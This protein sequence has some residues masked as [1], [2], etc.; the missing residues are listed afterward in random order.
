MPAS[1]LRA[2][3]AGTCQQAFLGA[4]C[5]HVPASILESLERSPIDR[6]LSSILE[7]LRST[8]RGGG[9]SAGALWRI[10]DT[11]PSDTSA[12]YATC[13]HCVMGHV[14]AH[15]RRQHYG[16]PVGGCGVRWCRRLGCTRPG[17]ATAH[18]R[19]QRRM[20]L[21][22]A[23]YI[24]VRDKRTHTPY[25]TRLGDVWALLAWA[26]TPAYIVRPGRA[27]VSR[28]LYSPGPGNSGA[29]GRTARR[30]HTR[31]SRWAPPCPCNLEC[32]N[33]T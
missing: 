16:R 32:L 17:P 7:S 22:L 29:I 6:K 30:R 5:G 26:V 23:T 11:M 15:G 12:V 28:P 27:T 31:A 3:S 1:I 19:P 33:L 8:G 14:I 13:R 25:V 20:L 21:A 18:S 9:L 24:V 10:R 2:H 4:F